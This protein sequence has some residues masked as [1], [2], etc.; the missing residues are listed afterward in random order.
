M[1]HLPTCAVLSLALMS[2]FAIAQGATDQEFVTKAAEGGLA[3]VDL[4]RIAVEHGAAAEVRTFGQRMVDDHSKANKELKDVASK[5]GADVPAEPSAS[6]KAMAA[7]LQKKSGADFDKAYAK[8]MVKDHKED[9]AL[10]E[11]EATSGKNTDLKALAKE[12]L[13]T[14]KSHLKMAESLSGSK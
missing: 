4:G 8:A 2:S 1:N 5:A 14:L 7:Q 10:F 13:P 11:K 6:Q 3:E 9:I 12:T